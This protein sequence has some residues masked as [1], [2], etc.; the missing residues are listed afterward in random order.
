M[1]T[2]E[3]E[4]VDAPDAGAE[5]S[6]H[7]ADRLAGGQPGQRLR[8]LLVIEEPPRI[9]AMRRD[10]AVDLLLTTV[11]H[12]GAQPFHPAD[13]T[14]TSNTKTVGR[15]P[16]LAPRWDDHYRCTQ[17]VASAVDD[18]TVDHPQRYRRRARSAGRTSEKSPLTLEQA[19]QPVKVS[20]V[21]RGQFER[22]RHE[23]MFA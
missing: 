21:D 8:C 11:S 3:P 6:R 5:P 17:Q 10:C 14:G 7:L 23:R 4:V 13:R 2:T 12:E 16:A 19:G 15:L 9:R 1:R 20:G 18:V 22:V